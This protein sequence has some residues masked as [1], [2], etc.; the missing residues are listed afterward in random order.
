MSPKILKFSRR[1]V[2]RALN[3]WGQHDGAYDVA[4]YLETMQAPS[5]RDETRLHFEQIQRWGIR[6]FPGLCLV[7]D[8]G[9]H[10][11]AS[12]YVKP[13]RVATKIWL[14]SAL[15]QVYLFLN[16]RFAS[17]ESPRIV[18]APQGQSFRKLFL[19]C[20]VC[21]HGECRRNNA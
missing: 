7:K 4:S 17:H 10:M 14:S 16:L 18:I 8:D 13:R 9:L 11:I 20:G 19:V 1:S 12:G 3:Q 15:E 5:T 6:G 21:P 2:S